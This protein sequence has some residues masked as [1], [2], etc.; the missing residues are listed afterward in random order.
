MSQTRSQ[1]IRD[2]E[3]IINEYEHQLTEM[4]ASINMYEELIAKI[5]HKLTEKEQLIKVLIEEQEEN[6]NTFEKICKENQQLKRSLAKK[7]SEM[8]DLQNEIINLNEVNCTLLEEN[9]EIGICNNT[10]ITPLKMQ[11]IEMQKENTNLQNKLAKN[12]KAI[13][14]DD[15]DNPKI[16]NQQMRR[17]NNFT[18]ILRNK[19]K[20]IKKLKRKC[21]L[22]NKKVNEVRDNKE[23]QMKRNEL[24]KA[25]TINDEL[26]NQAKKTSNDIN[27]ITIIGDSCVRGMGVELYDVLGKRFNTCCYTYSNAPL[28]KIIDTAMEVLKKGESEDLIAIFYK[29]FL[30]QELK[31]YYNILSSLIIEAK[32]KNV[33]LLFNNVPYC[34]I[35]YCDQPFLNYNMYVQRINNKLNMLTLYG[36]DTFDII[37]LSNLNIKKAGEFKE[38]ILYNILSQCK[39]NNSPSSDSDKIVSINNKNNNVNFHTNKLIETIK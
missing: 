16:E 35:P 24:N 37:N 12:I 6:G 38:I 9:E 22:H 30:N 19:N 2:K 20:Q 21:I 31:Q 29:D 28:K 27:K 1:T 11:M 7:E 23:K 36:N 15:L 25:K 10:I 26:V 4:K 39:K 33:K 34:D 14:N 17:K 8:I 5:Q 3:K 32:V 13:C 18:K